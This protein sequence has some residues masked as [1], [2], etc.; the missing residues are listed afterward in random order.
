MVLYVCVCDCITAMTITAVC[1]IV[2]AD[3]EMFIGT[4]RIT[5]KA[6]TC[7]IL[8]QGV[9]CVRVQVCWQALMQNVRTAKAG[10]RFICFTDLTRRS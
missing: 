8:I 1:F 6:N 2:A 3:A 9:D 4:I 10:S 7:N 5:H